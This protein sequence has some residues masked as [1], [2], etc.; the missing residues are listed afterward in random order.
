VAYQ[1]ELTPSARRQFRRLTP[2]VRKRLAP[3]IDRLADAPRP[4]GAV[5]LSGSEHRYRPR[6]GDY[7]ILYELY[8]DRLVVTVVRVG[9]RRE[10]YRE[11]S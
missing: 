3:V 10:V 8:D 5:K 11:R 9:H 2:D 4:P 1:V 7:R 6:V